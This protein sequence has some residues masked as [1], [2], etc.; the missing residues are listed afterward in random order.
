[1]KWRD[2]TEQAI[3]RVTAGR[4]YCVFT[5]AE[6]KRRELGRICADTRTRG[7][8]PERT[9]ERVCQE[10]RDSRVLQFVDDR[11]TYLLLRQL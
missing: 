6:L 7:K 3:R 10:L 5:L 1:M 2:A 11:G 8:T 9:L 4:I